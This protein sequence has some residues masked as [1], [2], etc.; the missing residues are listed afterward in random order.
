[1]DEKKF[2]IQRVSGQPVT[3]EELILDLQ[4]LATQ[5]GKNT[6]GLKEY[7][8]IGKYDETTVSRRFG[9]WN[10]ALKVAG[11]GISNEVYLSDNRLYENILKLWEYY[12]RQPRRR[13]LALAPSQILQSPYLRRFGSWTKALQKFIDFTGSNE[14][15]GNFPDSTAL[16]SEEKNPRDPSLRLRFRVFQR[17]R[18]TCRSCGAS[19]AKQAGVELH[20]DHITPW[21]KGG[22][23]TFENLQTLCDRCNLGKGNIVDDRR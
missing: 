18:F 13:E 11:L 22:K 6:I 14:T 5:N 19:P 3:N 23:T 17:D 7:H 21:S 2:K 1:V 9:S 10:N 4:R 12:G 16:L 20:V 8:Q 15:S